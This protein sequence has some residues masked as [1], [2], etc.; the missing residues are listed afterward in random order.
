MA[1]EN[2]VRQVAEF[3]NHYLNNRKL[4]RSTKN[5]LDRCTVVSIFPKDI[6]EI[7]HTIEPGKFHL[8][9][10]TFEN[11]STLIIGSSSWWREIDIDQPMLEIPCSSIQIAES[12]VKDYCNGMLAWDGEAGPGLFFVLGEVSSLE[13][14]MKYKEKLAEV[15]E[16]Q[17]IWYMRLVKIADSLWARSNG[18]PLVIADDMRLA[19]RSL[20]LNEKPWLKDFFTIEK[21]KCVG[22]GALRDPEYPICPTCKLIDKNHPLAKDMKFAV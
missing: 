22:C 2:E 20:N 19:A 16:K 13:V 8:Q 18:N 17:N 12:I 3:S 6:F 4:I 1:L 5:P 21:V 14:K 7:K 15:N 9:P 10:G 11:P